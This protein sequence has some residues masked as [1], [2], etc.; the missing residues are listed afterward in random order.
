[1]GVDP[2]GEFIDTIFDV[3][4]LGMSVAEVVACPADPMAW[5][6]LVGDIVD[7]VPG[8]TGVG[9]IAKGLGA[10]RKATKAVD[11]AV[12]ASQAANKGWKV[13]D[14]ISKLTS[15]GKSPTW[16]TVRSRYWKNQAAN[17]SGSTCYDLTNINITRMR[18]GKAPIGIDNKPVNLHHVQGKAN[19]MYDFIEMTQ[20]AHQAFHKTYGYRNF[21]NILK[22]GIL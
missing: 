5:V 9:E 16:N 21:P 10:A 4:S 3:I 18:S 6:G 8:V 17:P 13:G 15:T 12:D 2:N 7:L 19:N 22:M 20:T 14:D 11:N 1:M